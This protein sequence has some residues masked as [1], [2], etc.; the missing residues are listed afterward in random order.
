MELSV[1]SESLLLPGNEP[2]ELDSLLELQVVA[3][4]DPDSL[5][6]I[7]LEE[8]P[9]ASDQSTVSGV[10]HSFIAKAVPDNFAILTAQAEVE[11]L[12]HTADTVI[13]RDGRQVSINEVR[14]GD[15]VRPSTRFLVASAAGASST[16][17][18]ASLGL[19][20]LDIP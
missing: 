3:S 6:I 10:V 1:A 16:G 2:D 12:S 17:H 20:G 14:V 11:I 5:S 4:F 15:L 19:S 7:K 18:R 8:L 9:L 13:H